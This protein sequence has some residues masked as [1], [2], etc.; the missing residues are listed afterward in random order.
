MNIGIET[1]SIIEFCFDDFRMK[2]GIIVEKSSSYLCREQG[3]EPATYLT[4]SRQNGIDDSENAVLTGLIQR[5]FLMV[6]LDK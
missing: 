3:Q 1:R 6:K 5:F 4:H 2:P